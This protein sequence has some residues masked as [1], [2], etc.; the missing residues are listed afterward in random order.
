MTSPVT[1][2]VLT[3]QEEANLRQVLSTV[4]WADEVLV[5]DSF[6]TDGTAELCRESGVRH[7]NV[8]FHGFGRLRNEALK[9]A[10]HD[11]VVSI[12]S[13]E[14]STP[15]FAAEV[16]ETLTAPKHAAYFVPRRN[17][18]LSRRSCRFALAR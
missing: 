12:D 9:L 6:S 4:M 14:R 5:V 3:H 10:S 16:R 1:L 7:V 17:F 2:Y 11:W 15:E 13:D 18:F 8:P